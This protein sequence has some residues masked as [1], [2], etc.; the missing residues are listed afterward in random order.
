MLNIKTLKQEIRLRVWRILEES[1]TARFPRPV[2]GRIPN[3]VN[4]EKAAERIFNLNI[5][6]K[7]EIVKSNPDSP[8]KHLRYRALLENKKVIMASPRLLHGFILLDPEIIPYREYSYASTIQ[9]AFKYGKFIK[10]I[11][12]PMIDLVVTGCVAVDK[13]GG[14]LGKGGGYAELEYAILR[15]LGVV[16]DETPVVTTVHDLQIVEKIPLEEHDLTVDIIATPSK[17]IHVTPKPRKPRG[18][19]WELLGDKANLPVIIELK[20]ILKTRGMFK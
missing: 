16:N 11:D 19:I 20:N 2:Y 5:W 12:I 4:A 9:G 10:L 17:L 13:Y 6:R 1:N 7:A 15:E 3:F 18:V 8:Q 14:R